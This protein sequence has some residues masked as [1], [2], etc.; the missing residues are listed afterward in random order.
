M[1]PSVLRKARKLAAEELFHYALS[2][3]GGRALS[4]GEVRSR[5][6]RRAAD[7]ADIEPAL[8]RLREY[9]F[10]DDEKFAE[11][12]ATA[13]RDSG[14]A[15]KAR[16]LRDLRQRSVSSGVA[17]KAVTEVFS[18]VDEVAA[19]EQWLKRK[20]RSVVLSEYLRDEKHLASAYRRLRYAGFGS[21]A[22]IG[23]LKRYAS[24]AAELEDDP[25]EGE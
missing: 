1:I 15:G 25:D 19:V 21:S 24:K 23:V 12:Y 6:N 14:I 13:R 20:Y 5:L 4:A 3:L 9:G 8:A 16:V 10:V 22:A 11:G 17:E 7:P 18:D 2:L